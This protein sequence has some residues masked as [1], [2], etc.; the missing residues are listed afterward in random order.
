MPAVGALDV[1]IGPLDLFV[2]HTSDSFEQFFLRVGEMLRCLV[3]QDSVDAFDEFVGC[4]SDHK[5]FWSMT[6]SG[7]EMT[8][9]VCG[10]T[11]RVSQTLPPMTHPR[12]IVVVPPR[13]VAPA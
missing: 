3:G 5:C 10:G 4:V 12:P 13:I 11:E 6:S 1:D 9:R 7:S 2:D 8:T